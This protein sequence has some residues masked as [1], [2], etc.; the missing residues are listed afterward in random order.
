MDA[1]A[2]ESLR[3]VATI[4]A[5]SALAW[6]HLVPVLS[7]MSRFRAGVCDSLF[8]PYYYKYFLGP[9]CEANGP[10]IC[11]GGALFCAGDAYPRHPRLTRAMIHVSDGQGIAE[12]DRFIGP[13]RRPG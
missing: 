4:V 6:F 2:T 9:F 10:R 13:S 11:A 3:L 8:A 5:G 12:V 1:V 7:S